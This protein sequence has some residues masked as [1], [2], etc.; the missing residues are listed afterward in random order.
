MAGFERTVSLFKTLPTYQW[1]ADA[2]IVPSTSATYTLDQ[3][4]AVAKDRFGESR[5]LER[6]TQ[7]D[8]LP[9]AGYEATWGCKGSNLNQVFYGYVVRGTYQDGDFIATGPDGDKR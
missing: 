1:L 4:Q 6:S 2:G 5:E 8:A 7:A 9:R 3:L